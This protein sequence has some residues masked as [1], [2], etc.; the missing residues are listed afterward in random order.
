MK[1]KQ[2]QIPHRQNTVKAAHKVTFIKQSPVLKGHLFL[3]MS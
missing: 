1:K 2:K 3:I